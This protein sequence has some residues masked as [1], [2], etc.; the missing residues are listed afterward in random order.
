MDLW[1]RSDVVEVETWCQTEGRIGTRRDWIL[2]DCATGQ[3]IGRATRCISNLLFLFAVRKKKQNETEKQTW[4]KATDN[5]VSD[6]SLLR[7]CILIY[8]TSIQGPW[9]WFSDLIDH[10]YLLPFNSFMWSCIA[11]IGCTTLAIKNNVFFFLFSRKFSGLV[12]WIIRL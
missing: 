4:M 10:F 8:W 2:K 6:Q 7:M 11:N 1:N 9:G 5:S 12:A 3:L